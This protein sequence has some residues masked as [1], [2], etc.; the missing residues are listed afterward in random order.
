M[1]AIRRI[2]LLVI[3]AFE[4][5][6]FDRIG[7]V[8]DLTDLPVE[9][10]VYTPEEIQAMEQAGNPFVTELLTTAIRLA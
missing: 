4:E 3:G 6:V 2:D 9:P 1:H 10:L 8:I 5:R 7:R